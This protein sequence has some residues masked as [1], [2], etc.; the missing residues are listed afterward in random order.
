MVDKVIDT[1]VPIAANGSARADDTISLDCRLACVTFLSEVL[2]RHTV[3][4]DA[5]GEVQSEYRVY[6][7]PKG[8]PGVGDRFYREILMSSPDRVKRLELEKKGDG[9][10][11]NVPNEVT[12]NFDP[13]DL[14]FVALALKCNVPVS[15][16]TDSDW[17]N[18]RALLERHG[19]RLDALCGYLVADWF[20]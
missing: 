20:E 6:L 16:A 11:E 5:L 14:K 3:V 12:D 1:N 17:V 10:F 13:S 19:V 15:F 4:L 8:E 9:N 18:C 7:S 2:A